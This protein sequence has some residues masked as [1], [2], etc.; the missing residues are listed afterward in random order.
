[1]LEVEGVTS[2]YGRMEVIRDLSLRVG[3][4]EIV[5]IIGP[6]GAGKSTAMKLVFGLLTPWTGQVRFEGENVGGL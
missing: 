2:G 5:T 3:D 6:N 1:M 4:G